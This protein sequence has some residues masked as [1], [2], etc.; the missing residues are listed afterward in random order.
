MIEFKGE[1]SKENK[2][3]LIKRDAIGLFIISIIMALIMGIPMLIVGLVWE[4]VFLWFS[5]MAFMMPIILG[6]SLILLIIPKSRE[7][8]ANEIRPNTP[9]K[10]TIIDDIIEA[11]YEEKYIEIMVSEVR[12][13]IDVGDLYILVGYPSRDG[14]YWACQ[15]NL[16]TKGT[17]EEFEE[18]F[19]DKLVRKIK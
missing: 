6:L 14:H 17:L 13:V 11:E 18:L 5:L 19:A 3:Y 9:I 1:L 10:V 2:L 12:K 4:K 15:K 8:L 7:K 16:L